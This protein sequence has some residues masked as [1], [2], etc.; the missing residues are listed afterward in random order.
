M[1][2]IRRLLYTGTSCVRYRSD[3][4]LL[5]STHW[6][7]TVR[8]FDQKRL[9][10]LAILRHH[11]DSV[12]AVDFVEESAYPYINDGKL[13]M[14]QKDTGTTSVPT[15]VHHNESYC[16]PKVDNMSSNDQAGAGG[17]CGE[18]EEKRGLSRSVFA[19]ASKDC[20]IALWD[21]FA[22]SFH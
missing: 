17:K 18:E 2:S 11:R 6:D 4:R 15:D 13:N 20:T 1:L 5:V 21:L 3:G 19:T 14:E 12:Y 7:Y 22:D 8:I 10:P 16:N 9:K